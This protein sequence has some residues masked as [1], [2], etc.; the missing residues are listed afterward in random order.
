MLTLPQLPFWLAGMGFSIQRPLFS[1]DLVLA[2]ALLCWRPRWGMVMLG[3]ALA[4]DLVR[5][6]ALGYHFVTPFEFL[7]A[8]RFAGL[9]DAGEV[10]SWR[11]LLGVAGLIVSA[12]LLLKLSR[13]SDRP[14][15]VLVAAV[16]LLLGADAFN[17]T[18]QL[19][20][21]GGDR[22][23]SQLNIAGSPAW[24]VYS[25]WRA[26][27]EQANQPLVPYPAPLAFQATGDWMRN[28]ED[29]SVLV[30]IVE[31]FGV[32]QS[33]VLQAWLHARLA[34]PRIDQRWKVR[35]ARE[36]FFGPTTRGELRTLCGLNAHY[37]RLTA[38]TSTN[39][40]P[41]QAQAKGY[42][43]IGLHGFSMRMF[44]RQDWWPMIGL[45][46]WHFSEAQAARHCNDA[47]PGVCDAEVLHQ[48]MALVDAPKRFVY[49]LTLDT[50]L[51]LPSTTAA[52]D[53]QLTAICKAE[54]VPATACAL[55]AR[56]GSLLTVVET[57]LAGVRSPPM[58]VVVGDHAPP[59]IAAD[60]RGAF[61]ASHVPLY[62][63]EPR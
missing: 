63:L 30:I 1:L 61:S 54:Q 5:S 18:A 4:L 43:S 17:G 35:E 37:G 58:V 46:P 40:L 6:A 13:M 38:A 29:A 11:L 27:R 47:F 8:A 49:A 39:C 48:A 31:A 7:D 2:S 19:F 51:P 23:R 60:S 44:D 32:P 34:T 3:L 14:A 45:K 10:L 26:V 55:L 42:E 28:H 62:I 56:I 20:G 24:N 41:L 15:W 12:L 36:E 22:T 16:P 53:P 52:P 25:T 9:I 57:G 50:H 59:F 33:E 21:L